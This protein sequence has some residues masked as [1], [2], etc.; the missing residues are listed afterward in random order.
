[1]IK[2]YYEPQFRPEKNMY[3]DGLA[4]YLADITPLCEVENFQYVKHDLDITVKINWNQEGVSDLPFNYAVIENEGEEPFYYWIIDS[5]WVAQQTLALRLNM[6]TVNSLGQGEE[7]FANPR[8]FS[9]ETQ[10]MRQHMDRYEKQFYWNPQLGGVLTRKIHRTPEGLTLN[11]EKISD[12]TLR[13]D[14]DINWYLMYRTEGGLVNTYLIPETPLPYTATTGTAT[15]YDSSVIMDNTYQFTKEKPFDITIYYANGD[16]ANLNSTDIYW[17]P[18]SGGKSWYSEINTLTFTKNGSLL[19]VVATPTEKFTDRSMRFPSW[20]S[21]TIGDLGTLDLP[22]LSNV[23]AF[24]VNSGSQVKVNGTWQ[25]IIGAGEKVSVY[26]KGIS[27]I[28]RAD[29]T[30]I[31]IIKVPYCPITDYRTNDEW[32]I[33]SGAEQESGLLEYKGEFLPNLSQ[34]GFLEIDMTAEMRRVVGV[35][36]IREDSR[37]NP[38]NESKLFHSEFHTVKA[39]YDSFSYPIE[40]ERFSYL[41]PT[42]ECVPVSFKMTS[43]I[44]SKMGFRFVPERIGT[45][46]YNEDFGEYLL[47]TRNNEEL[48]LNSEYLNYIKNG[49]NY[50]KKANALALETAQRNAILSGLTAAAGIGA[51]FASAGLGAVGAVSAVGLGGSAAS[52]V[53]N[54]TNT[55][56]QLSTLRQTQENSLRQKLNQLSLQAASVAGTDDIDLMTWYSGNRLHVMRYDLPEYARDTV[57][58]YFDI[59]GYK[60]DKYE[61]PDVDSRIWYNFLQCDPVFKEQGTGKLKQAWLDDLRARY[62][63]GITVFHNRDGVYNFEQRYENWE[64]WIT[65]GSN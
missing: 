23:R 4:A 27:E 48:I 38:D 29:P 49:I 45:Y 20:W 36:D 22:S 55:V 63:A 30:I 6:D 53:L 7:S 60:I 31:K 9:E 33:T 54:T 14:L 51:T 41:D 18:P 62:N 21:S 32:Q 57:Y 13:E 34:E 16:T 35:N 1:M 37:K 39:V 40:M 19:N 61:T 47:I 43:T 44:N 58:N 52:A 26:L 24:S 46:H 11:Q 59:L 17:F 3:V 15:A 5:K 42:E 28:D 12:E 10:V 50:D 25:N 8:N 64:K 65:D 2:L 56:A